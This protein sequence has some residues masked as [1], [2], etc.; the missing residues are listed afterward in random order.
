LE[1]QKAQARPVAPHSL[2]KLAAGGSSGATAAAGG[3]RGLGR[4][5]ASAAQHKPRLQL[6][7]EPARAAREAESAAESA[8]AAS[9]EPGSG[10]GSE[11]EPEPAPEPR[12]LRD[13]GGASRSRSTPKAAPKPAAAKARPRA[14]AA[15][16]AR[17]TVDRI[18]L[19]L[20]LEDW[21]RDAVTGFA[22]Q[23]GKVPVST[24]FSGAAKHKRREPS[25][26][27]IATDDN[28]TEQPIGTRSVDYCEAVARGCWVVSFAWITECMEGKGKTSWVSP[29]KYEVRADDAGVVGIAAHS[30][31][32]AM[33]QRC[34]LF[35]GWS[36]YLGAFNQ[37]PKPKPAARGS[38]GRSSSRGSSKPERSEF[39]QQITR[40]FQQQG[41]TLLQRPPVSVKEGGIAGDLEQWRDEETAKSVVLLPQDATGDVVSDTVSRCA[42][43]GSFLMP[44]WILDCVAEQRIVPTEEYSMQHRH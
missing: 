22:A 39:E 41:G 29:E 43:A 16:A 9:Y 31:T 28:N 8:A 40:I 4:A 34:N 44:R 15:K 3:G 19:D 27:I 24:D 7:S 38:R 2:L 14:S 12:R 30:R 5:T 23:H 32:Q 10:S 6:K 26:Y 13:R 17:V 21:Q 18:V 42:G 37:S 36:F 25:H 11:S 1:P 20:G 35:H 33:T